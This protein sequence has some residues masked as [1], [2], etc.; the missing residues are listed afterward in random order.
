MKNFI[1]V[2]IC[3]AI[4]IFIASLPLIILF[5]CMSKQFVKGLTAGA[6]KG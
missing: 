1:I 6:V 4:S 2:T 5:F 3:I